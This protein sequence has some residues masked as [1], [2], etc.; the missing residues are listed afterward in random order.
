MGTALEKYKDKLAKQA[1][2]YASDENE[3]GKFITTRGGVLKY[4]EEEMPGNEM[5]VI[6]LDSVH[7]NTYYPDRFDAENVM[8]PK[9]FAFGRSDKDME[10]HGDVPDPDDDEAEYSYFELQSPTGWC[11]DC[12]HAQ[13]GSADTGK[14]KAC[15]NRRR[16]ALIPAGHF[17]VTGKGR[18]KLSEPEVFD[19]PDH[20]KD[21]EIA[22][23]KIPVTSVKNWSRY[24]HSIRK[25]H[26]MPP[27]GVLTHMYIEPDPKY[28]FK[29][30]FEC[31]E[32]I[33]D[34][35]ILEALFERN[36]EARERIEQ[37]YEEPSEEEKEAP[38]AKARSGLDGL[39]KN[40]RKS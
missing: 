17:V 11:S 9:C 21:A 24:V 37:P 19:D 35:A 12:P 33:E 39:K 26:N 8:P 16:L 34:E 13:W 36:E 4:G 27:F 10:A 22:F 3:G 28:Q 1:D 6:V 23:L 32:A 29:I 20:F 15:S 7:E 40:R 38:K 14:G 30:H 31:L 5:L 25:D 18:N 2:D